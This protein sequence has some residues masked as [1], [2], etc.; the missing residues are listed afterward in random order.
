MRSQSNVLWVYI[1]SQTTVLANVTCYVTSPP[2]LYS[3]PNELF[4]LTFSHNSCD[5]HHPVLSPWSS[6]SHRRTYGN[7]TLTISSTNI[8]LA[9]EP[10]RRLQIKLHMYICVQVRKPL[11]LSSVLSNIK[12][13]LIAPLEAGF[14]SG[15]LSE[16]LH[17]T[18]SNEATV[19]M[20]Y[21]DT[22]TTN[23]TMAVCERLWTSVAGYDTLKG[24][25]LWQSCSKCRHITIVW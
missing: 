6:V 24:T 3:S 10:K 2:R 25:L 15:W 20:L 5:C 19:S 18:S 17:V 4:R 21:M 12:K 22:T 16:R 1:Q 11:F 7:N 13:G 14:E 23:H 9:G 8:T